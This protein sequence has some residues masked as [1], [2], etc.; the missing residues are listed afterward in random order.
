MRILLLSDVGG[1]APAIP[2]ELVEGTDF[3]LLAGDVTLGARHENVIRRNFEA[4][5]GLIPPGKRVFY[6]P[7]NHD[8]PS[9][10]DVKAWMPPNFILLHDKHATLHVNGFPRPVLVLGFGGAKLGLYNNFAFDEEEMSS[11]LSRLFESTAAE[12]GA[13]TPFTILLV[14]DPPSNTK[15]DYTFMK[16][17]VGSGAVRKAIESYQP[18]L[19]VAGHIHE[20]PGVDKI[21]TTTCVNAGEA[22]QGRYAVI[23]VEPGGIQV[24]FFPPGEP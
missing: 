22:R 9:V 7:G 12:R 20:S 8:Q 17:H 10:A 4:V 15:L 6:I 1:K 19:A 21:G 13:S 16:T 18:D 24:D 11:S 2:R 23:R 5:A 14:H 3:V